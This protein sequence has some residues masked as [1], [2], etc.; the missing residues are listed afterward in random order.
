[1]PKRV[2]AQHRNRMR[3]DRFVPEFFKSQ[4]CLEIGDPDQV[5]HFIK[6]TYWLH[7]TATGPRRID[8]RTDANLKPLL[9]EKKR[10]EHVFCVRNHE[11][12]GSEQLRNLVTLLLK[13]LA[14]QIRVFGSDN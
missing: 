6:H 11:L 4:G 5:H 7:A 3:L 13:S 9:V 8:Q 1:M 12:T 2:R 14:N 10:R